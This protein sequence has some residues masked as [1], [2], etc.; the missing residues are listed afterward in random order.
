MPF[1][2]SAIQTSSRARFA[3]VY[4]A[5]NTCQKQDFDAAVKQCEISAVGNPVLALRNA[6][7]KTLFNNAA[8]VMASAGTNLA[9]NIQQRRTLNYPRTMMKKIT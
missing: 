1:V 5:A 3:R 4:L 8:V 6:E 9:E 7:N 2:L